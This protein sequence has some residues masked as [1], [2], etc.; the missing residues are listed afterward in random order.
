MSDT[1]L[2]TDSLNIWVNYLPK[3]VNVWAI[4]E[5]GT[6]HKGEV[7][8]INRNKFLDPSKVSTYIAS[9][10]YSKIPKILS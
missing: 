7:V 8:P 5:S 1:G 4:L 2:Y 9:K 10:N 3:K 6:Y